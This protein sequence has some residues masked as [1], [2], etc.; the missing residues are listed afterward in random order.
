MEPSCGK[1]WPHQASSGS[2]ENKGKILLH[3]IVVFRVFQMSQLWLSVQIKTQSNSQG[4]NGQK[5]QQ[6]ERIMQ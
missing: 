5:I 1:R 4:T 6:V 2:V 3:I